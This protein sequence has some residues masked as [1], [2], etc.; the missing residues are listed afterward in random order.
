MVIRCGA[1]SIRT[2][3]DRVAGLGAD[4]VAFTPERFAEVIRSETAKWSKLVR[5]LNIRME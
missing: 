5:E 1:K 2:A 3:R 4:V